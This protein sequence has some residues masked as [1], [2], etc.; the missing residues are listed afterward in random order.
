VILVMLGVVAFAVAVATPRRR[1]RPR[2]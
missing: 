1:S 2:G